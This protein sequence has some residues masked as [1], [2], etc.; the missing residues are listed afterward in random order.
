MD[1]A[2]DN[3]PDTEIR[4]GSYYDWRIY[5]IFR[6]QSAGSVSFYKSLDSELTIDDGDDDF[7]AHRFDRSVNNQDVTVV[8]S[9]V[10]H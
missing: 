9:S 2:G 4:L 1:N 7:A 5:R 6:D 3:S 10:G 8:D